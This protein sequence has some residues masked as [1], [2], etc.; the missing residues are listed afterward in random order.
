MGIQLITGV[1]RFFSAAADFL[2]LFL[3]PTRRVWCDRGQGGVC[4]GEQQ[5]LPRV[6]SSLSAS[7]RHLAHPTWRSQGG[8]EKE[9][10][11]QT[12]P[13]SYVSAVRGGYGSF[14]AS[15]DLCVKLACGWHIWQ[16]LAIW[17]K[18]SHYV[19]QRQM[20]SCAFSPWVLRK[21][22]P[23]VAESDTQ[24]LPVTLTQIE[25]LW[26]SFKPL[27]RKMI[28]VCWYILALVSPSA[29]THRAHLKISPA[30]TVSLQINIWLP[31]QLT[32]LPCLRWHSG[33]RDF[34]RVYWL[35]VVVAKR[36]E[37]RMKGKDRAEENVKT[38]T[39]RI[40]VYILAVTIQAAKT[41]TQRALFWSPFLV[42]L[43]GGFVALNLKRT[44]F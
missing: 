22:W 21:P 19:F 18:L 34:W 17:F 20:K 14:G 12:P 39:D 42:T 4:D 25:A 9:N 36:E 35:E 13:N 1:L 10:S 38:N 24:C 41:T 32:G 6:Y 8:G 40:S 23:H 37:G 2:S 26:H 5:H 11:R 15:W 28:P 3:S 31:L 29:S 33:S 30:L 16:P 44:E 43:Q 7:Y 27:L